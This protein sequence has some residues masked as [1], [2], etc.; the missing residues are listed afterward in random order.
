MKNFVFIL[1]LVFASQVCN[2]NKIKAETKKGKEVAVNEYVI[3][4]G[5]LSE[6]IDGQKLP[7][8]F[9]NV[10]IDGTTAITFTDENGNF[11][12]KTKPEDQKI[13]CTFRGFENFE[14]TIKS[15]D[16]VETMELDITLTKK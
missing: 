15:L 1:V 8:A 2:A 12:L 9:A 14:K 16:A 13:V 10:Y 11:E 4:R 5:K 3:I 7:L 6:N